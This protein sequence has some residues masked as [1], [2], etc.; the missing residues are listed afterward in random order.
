MKVDNNIAKKYLEQKPLNPAQI[1]MLRKLLNSKIG[2]KLV[3]K[4]VGEKLTPQDKTNIL[5]YLEQQEKKN[6]EE[7]K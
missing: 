3:E 6:K 1:K 4:Q 5:A 2:T 7:K